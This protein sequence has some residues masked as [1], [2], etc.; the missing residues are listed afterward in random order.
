VPDTDFGATASKEKPED[1][2]EKLKA[3]GSAMS[4]ELNSQNRRIDNK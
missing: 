3:L 2:P 1:E 4:E